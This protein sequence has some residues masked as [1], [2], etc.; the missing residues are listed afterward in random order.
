[1]LGGGSGPSYVCL[2]FVDFS[3]LFTIGLISRKCQRLQQGIAEVTYL[4]HL[5]TY[6][7]LRTPSLDTSG[8][9]AVDSRSAVGLSGHQGRVEITHK[10][11]KCL[12]WVIRMK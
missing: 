1:V 7:S 12:I 8:A 4:K 10:K 5:A 11:S 2:D 9:G 3:P 6:W